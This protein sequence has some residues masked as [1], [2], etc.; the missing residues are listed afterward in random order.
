[1]S[2]LLVVAPERD[3]RQSLHFALE[4]EGY[5]VRA[6]EHIDW[7]SLAG[8]SFDCAVLD[9][10]AAERNAA[11]TADFCLRFAPVILLAN[12]VPHVLSDHATRTVL[13]PLLGAALAAAVRDVLR[14]TGTP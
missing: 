9:Q 6:S 14:S 4:A 7:V 3:L 11:E 2:H 5:R 10:H 13:K 1:M 8:Q 12:T